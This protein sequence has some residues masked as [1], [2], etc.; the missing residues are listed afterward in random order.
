MYPHQLSSCPL[1]CLFPVNIPGWDH[2]DMN[3]CKCQV[4]ISKYLQKSSLE[5]RE[6]EYLPQKPTSASDA[7]PT[8]EQK[9]VSCHVSAMYP[10]S[11]HQHKSPLCC[12][13][14]APTDTH[15]HN[16]L[17]KD[18]S[19]TSSPKQSCRLRQTLKNHTLLTDNL[20]T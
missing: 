6:T 7:H 2:I 5:T 20:Q 17:T 19:Q 3:D 4:N 1:L 8:R 16:L 10:P 9:R 14:L 15:T 18:D 12:L 13:L 11:T